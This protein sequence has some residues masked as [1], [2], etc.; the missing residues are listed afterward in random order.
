MIHHT[1]ALTVCYCG[2][3]TNILNMP[4]IMRRIAC[5][6]SFYDLNTRIKETTAIG[7]SL[8][9]IIGKIITQ[10]V[11]R[12]LQILAYYIYPESQYGFRASKS[13][14]DRIL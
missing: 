9:S 7:I 4:N 12:R 10:V 2:H 6:T 1:G 3:L 5:V 14:I 13:A 8:L 11:L